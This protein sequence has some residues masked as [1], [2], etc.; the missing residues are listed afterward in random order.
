MRMLELNRILP[1]RFTTKEEDIKPP[2]LIV[3]DRILIDFIDRILKSEFVRGHA[4]KPYY[5]LF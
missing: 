5:E 2:V 3:D 4:K 1:E